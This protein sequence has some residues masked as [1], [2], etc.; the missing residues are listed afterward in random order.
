M[1][2]TGLEANLLLYALD[3]FLG[4][5]EDGRV[6]S[7]YPGYKKKKVQKLRNRLFLAHE[8]PEEKKVR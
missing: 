8:H 4:V 3:K 5:D 6:Q 1:K 7:T 2:I